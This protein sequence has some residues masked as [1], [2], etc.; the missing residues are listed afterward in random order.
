MS[1]SI[2]DQ[3]NTI[4]KKFIWDNKRAKIKHSSLIANYDQGGL[5]DIDIVTKIKALQL[6]WIKRL[7]D[8]NFHPWKIIPTHFLSNISPL[9]CNIFYPNFML[10]KDIK[11]IPDF[12]QNIL[13]FWTEFSHASPLTASSVLSECVWNNRHITVGN[14]VIQPSFLSANHS[15]FLQTFLMS[16]A[17]L[18]PG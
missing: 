14:K 5:K 10:D 9:G 4:H 8:D 13:N 17:M 2:L 16:T 3:L 18:S 7:L 1:D 12:Y 6:S 15:I 11:N